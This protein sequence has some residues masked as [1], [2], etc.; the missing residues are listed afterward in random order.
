MKGL[1]GPERKPNQQLQYVVQTTAGGTFSHCEESNPEAT[2]Y[3]P[4][5]VVIA[6]A[7]W[8]MR[9]ALPLPTLAA[10]VP[11]RISYTYEAYSYHRSEKVANMNTTGNVML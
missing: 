5:A 1:A 11:P 4:P 2:Q 10:V 9:H 8:F 3:H 7:E 6:L